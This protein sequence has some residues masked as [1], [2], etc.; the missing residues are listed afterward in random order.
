VAGEAARLYMGLSSGGCTMPETDDALALPPGWGPVVFLAAVAVLCSIGLGLWFR[1]MLHTTVQ[2]TCG[3]TQ[4]FQPLGPDLAGAEAGPP[5]SREPVTVQLDDALF[6]DELEAFVDRVATEKGLDPEQLPT[7]REMVMQMARSG[8]LPQ[9]DELDVEAVLEAHLTH[10]A[11]Q[12][13]ATD[14]W[15]FEHPNGDDAAPKGA[16]PP[17][18]PPQ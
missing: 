10:V 8:L 7:A 13:E 9:G 12:A 17:P 18:P 1:A 14:D 11:Q 5:P 6:T 3:Q 15:S 4:Q 2:E 16:A